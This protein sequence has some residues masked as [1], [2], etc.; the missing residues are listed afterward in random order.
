MQDEL[1]E[2][3][4]GAIRHRISENLAVILMALRAGTHCADF[5][6]IS[7]R[8]FDADRRVRATAVEI[9]DVVSPES[10]RPLIIPL[11]EEDSLAGGSRIA[12]RRYQ[13]EPDSDPIE[14]LFSIPDDWVRACTAYAVAHIDPASYLAHLKA[15]Q[16]AS[17]P[18]L[19]F[20]CGYALP[21]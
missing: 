5:G 12:A 16:D 4:R 3:W 19:A 8:I 14:A 6:R 20:S 11:L 15:G 2:L 1:D 10:L 21:L 9:L 13:I 7:L 17:D 18:R